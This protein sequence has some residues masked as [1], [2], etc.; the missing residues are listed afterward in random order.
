LNF[1]WRI[2]RV[3]AV[4]LDGLDQKVLFD[5]FHPD[6]L[7][8]GELPGVVFDLTFCSFTGEHQIYLHFCGSIGA[9]LLQFTK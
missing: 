6:G 7:D 5:S 3:T 8:F 4:H 2:L 1:L 9:V